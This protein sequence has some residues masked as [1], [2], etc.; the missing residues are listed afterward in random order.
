[1]SPV[2]YQ[3]KSRNFWKGQTAKRYLAILNLKPSNCWE[4]INFGGKIQKNTKNQ[5]FLTPESMVEWL[6]P[7]LYMKISALFAAGIKLFPKPKP[8]KMQQTIKRK[9]SNANFHILGVNKDLPL[10]S[11]DFKVCSWSH[12]L[13]I[14]NI[15]VRPQKEK[16][17]FCKSDNRKRNLAILNLKMS[18][19]LIWERFQRTVLPEKNGSPGK[20]GHRKHGWV[21][22]R[23]DEG[24]GS[25]VG[26]GGKIFLV[27]AHEKH[28]SKGFDRSG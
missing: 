27:A 21:V 23:T 11:K 24:A 1:M 20:I 2:R 14:L 4:R 18:I 7:V 28:V 6:S 22:I 13:K 5:V 9:N 10:L 17:N 12:L 8:E 25:T 15:P 26:T 3:V 19:C 16:K